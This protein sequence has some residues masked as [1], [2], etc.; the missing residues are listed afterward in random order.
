MKLNYIFFVIVSLLI[1]DHSI[2]QAKPYYTQ[3]IL[4][5]YILN[6]ALSGIE[7]YTDVKLSYKDQWAGIDGAPTTQYFTIHSPIGKSDTRTSINSYDIKGINPRGKEYWKEYTAPDPHHGI[8]ITLINDLAGYI[9]RWSINGTYAY[10]TPLS[11]NT[12]LAAGLSVGMSSV[13]IDRTK[14]NFGE[15]DPND[16]V[17]GYSNSEL[18]KIRP[19]IGA[20]LWLYSPRYFAGVSILNIIPA[21]Q[22]CVSNANYGS[23]ITPNYFITGGYRINFADD[24][25]IIPSFMYQYW[26]PQLSGLHLN[27]KIQY[28]DILWIGAGY[29]FSNMI[30]GYSSY[31]GI[32]VANAFNLSY[33]YE[34]ATTSR[35]KNYTGNTN[36]LLIGIIFGNKYGDSCPKNV[37]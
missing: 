30:A 18:K 23:S 22:R 5:N 21:K 3:Y 9:N 4:N 6:P 2:G 37:W 12:S 7:N 27:T 29:R 19:E 31:L 24:F 8:G 32:N 20:G 1:H 28:R 15:L 35:L 17:V 14:I 36:E 10:H 25:N 26:E 11:V 34:V 33:S 16:P 13:N